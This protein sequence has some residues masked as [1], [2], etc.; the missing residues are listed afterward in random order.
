MTQRRSLPDRRRSWWPPGAHSGS[1]GPR[2]VPGPAPR[3]VIYERGEVRGAGCDTRCR[4]RWRSWLGSRAWNA[5][6]TPSRRPATPSAPPG[7]NSVR[8]RHESGPRTGITATP[9]VGG[10]KSVPGPEYRTRA[11]TSW[12]QRHAA[13][14]SRSYAGARQALPRRAPRPHPPPLRGYRATRA[15]RYAHRK[16]WTWASRAWATIRRAPSRA[17]AASVWATTAPGVDAGLAEWYRAI[18]AYLLSDVSSE[19]RSPLS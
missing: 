10:A 7:S 12:S 8:R 19:P 18:A 3:C 4:P 1:A 14:T 5:G 9:F 17:T 16:T 13:G 2:V 11:A 15:Y 6:G